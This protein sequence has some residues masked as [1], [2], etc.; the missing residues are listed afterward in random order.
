MESNEL[1]EVLNEVVAGQEYASRVLQNIDIGIWY[2][3]TVWIPLVLILGIFWT[4]YVQF[5]GR[6]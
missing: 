1:L 4:V 5:F 6:E 3:A 2:I